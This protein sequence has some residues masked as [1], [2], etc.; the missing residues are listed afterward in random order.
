MRRRG[1]VIGAV[2]GVAA[3]GAIVVAAQDDPTLPEQ[4][5]ELLEIEPVGLEGLTLDSW[6]RDG[7]VLQAEY[8][9]EG[10]PAGFELR[11]WPTEDAAREWFVTRVE[12]LTGDEVE[13]SDRVAAELCVEPTRC[14]GYDG[15]RTFE[16][17]ITA[18]DGGEGE[19]LDARLLVRIARKHWYRVMG[20]YSE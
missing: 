18:A 11:L 17:T 13:K 4:A 12:D 8:V 16:G 10:A 6:T 5:Q 9:G 2:V 7:V 1:I 14:I 15:Y 20:G 3:L 19:L